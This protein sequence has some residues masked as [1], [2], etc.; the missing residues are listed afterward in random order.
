MKITNK[1][2][3]WESTRTRAVAISIDIYE[4]NINDEN[5][6]NYLYT[7]EFEDQKELLNFVFNRDGIQIR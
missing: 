3:K 6:K 1:N 7:L 5:E 4:Q 2:Q